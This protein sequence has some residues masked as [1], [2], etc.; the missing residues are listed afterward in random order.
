ML[1]VALVVAAASLVAACG[2]TVTSTPK[3]PNVCSIGTL[4]GCDNSDK[5]FA[6]PAPVEKEADKEPEKA[7]AAKKP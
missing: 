2:F 3:N 6:A 5:P 4:Y 1:R 7:D